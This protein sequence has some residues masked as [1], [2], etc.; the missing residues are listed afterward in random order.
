MPENPSRQRGRFRG[1]WRALVFLALLGGAGWP[2]AAVEVG[3]SRLVSKL[4]NL[5]LRSWQGSA[6]QIE[7]VPLAVPGG[8]GAND[9][10]EAD[11]Q[12]IL[13]IPHL[14]REARLGLS[15]RRDAYLPL[16]IFS[17]ATVVLPLS[18]RARFA[19]LVFGTPIILFVALLSLFV[20]ASF[21]LGSV[22]DAGI[23][24]W[25]AE[26]AQFLF[27]CWLTPPG[28]RVIAPLLFAAA[29]GLS[30]EGLA[31]VQRRR[32]VATTS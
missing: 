5:C 11:T 9:N 12:L 16:V 8:H 26:L 32:G 19:C 15:L 27:D 30:A 1:W 21:L 4:G 7:L 14:T 22:P 24:A 28:N 13:R 6:A 18:R 29:L 3:F 23:R 10:V 20:L 31:G 17:A 2:C 25:Q